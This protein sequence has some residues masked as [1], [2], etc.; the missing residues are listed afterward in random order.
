MAR[1]NSEQLAPSLQ[2]RLA[3]IYLISGDEALLVQECCDLVRKA[4]HERG[5][6]EQERFHAE[7]N[8][9]W[10]NLLL[11]TNSLSLFSSKKLFEVRVR[12]GKPGDD[13][14]KALIEYCRHISDDNLLLLVLPKLDKSAQSSAWFKAVNEVGEFVQIWPVNAQQLPRWIQ[15]RLRAAGI[16][17]N[18]EAVDVLC[19]KVEG[20]LLAAAQEIEKLK[21]LCGDTPVD[22]KAMANLVSD[23]A[24][25]NI[26]ELVDRALA[27]DALA[28]NASL[29]GLRSEGTAAIVILNL[30][31]NQIS[32]LCQIR[33]AMEQGHGFDNAAS[34]Q[35]VWS[36][37]MGITRQA[38]ERL[39]LRDLY[40]LL[41][42]CSA[43]DRTVKGVRKGSEWDDLS[44]IVTRMCGIQ[45]LSD[46][47]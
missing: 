38:V 33:E 6:H 35:R 17:A 46:I 3:P 25:Y 5:F 28:A 18:S 32:T 16:Q 44:A 9:D 8:F 15:Q 19:S 4:A 14:S 39:K 2:K 37:R 29:N 34:A 40:V 24:R 36:S 45:T 42:L 12:N 27:G 23:S 47:A 11:D 20:N 10:A 43:T 31:F 22:A 41:R 7:A 21:I 26:F 30:L 13:G 1:L